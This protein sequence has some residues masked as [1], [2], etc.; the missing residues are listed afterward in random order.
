MVI[1]DGK[2]WWLGSRA[3]ARAYA[4]WLNQHPVTENIRCIGPYQHN[5]KIA[6][7]VDTWHDLPTLEKWQ[8]GLK[9]LTCQTLFP[10]YKI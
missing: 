4:Q 7:V 3:E 6:C 9:D 10:L 8:D 2:L 5:G 1:C